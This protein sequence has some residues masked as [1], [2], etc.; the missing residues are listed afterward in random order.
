MAIAIVLFVVSGRVSGG[1]V[2]PPHDFCLLLPYLLLWLV[3]VLLSLAEMKV[4]GWPA[5]CV[6][7]ED[8]FLPYL[9]TLAPL[10]TEWEERTCSC[11][12]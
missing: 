10:H 3:Q 6:W 5:C 1:S 12:I 4:S 7:G 8:M 11:L 2:L 9:G